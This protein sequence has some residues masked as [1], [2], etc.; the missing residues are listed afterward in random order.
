MKSFRITLGILL[1][2]LFA[3]ASTNELY[4]A[5]KD[6]KKSSKKTDKKSKKDK[7]KDDKIA[8]KDDKSAPKKEIDK[9]NPFYR[10][11]QQIDALQEKAD[12]TS[13]E[14]RKKKL[15]ARIKK[16]KDGIKKDHESHVA[17]LKKKLHQKELQLEREN[18]AIFRK[19][20]EN[21]IKTIQDEITKWDAWAGVKAP[22]AKGGAP[23]AKGGKPAVPAK[24]DEPLDL[25][26]PM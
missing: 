1:T 4:A 7:K 20:L 21:D 2:I 12:K 24:E 18:H 19:R 6:N 13:N 8:K 9:N 14:N 17:R 23:A 10:D 15:N 11:L 3:F 26:I 16:L 25:D 22:A 5:A